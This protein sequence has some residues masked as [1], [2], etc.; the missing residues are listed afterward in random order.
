MR[1]SDASTFF[2]HAIANALQRWAGDEFTYWAR[3]KRAA[4]LAEWINGTTIHDI[5]QRYS[6]P[7][8][9]QV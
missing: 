1:I 3:C 4:V 2:G 9:G 6:V 8:G 7:F 5:E